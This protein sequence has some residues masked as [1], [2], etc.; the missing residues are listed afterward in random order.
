MDNPLRLKEL[1]HSPFGGRFVGICQLDLQK[2]FGCCS[3]S[4]EIQA[5]KDCA[6][7]QNGIFCRV[8]DCGDAD[9]LFGS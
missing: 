4:V 2:V 6:L 3:V 8:S 5:L 9:G 1:S 7:S